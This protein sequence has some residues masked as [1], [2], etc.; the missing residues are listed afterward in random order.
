MT[1]SALRKKIVLIPRASAE[2]RRNAL[3]EGAPG[4]RRAARNLARDW[5]VKI[6]RAKAIDALL[7]DDELAYLDRVEAAVELAPFLPSE[8]ID[9]ALALP[10]GSAEQED[11]KE[12]MFNTMVGVLCNWSASTIR[13]AASVWARANI[14]WQI[15]DTT[16]SHRLR[17]DTTDSMLKSVRATAEHRAKLLHAKHRR[18]RRPS[19]GRSMTGGTAVLAFRRG[20]AFLQKHFGIAFPVQ[21]AI[22][23]RSRRRGGHRTRHGESLSLKM[24]TAID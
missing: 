17:G 9:T 24:V 21:S 3:K 5:K 14:F 23:L 20:L 10:A 18:A 8:A 4:W 11:P 6:R 22:L 16:P 12:V 15:T 1:P 19:V 13:N 2:L 7:T